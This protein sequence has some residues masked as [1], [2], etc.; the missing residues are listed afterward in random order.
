[1]IQSIW[2]RPQCRSQLFFALD[3]CPVCPG[4]LFGA[5]VAELIIVGTLER[6]GQILLLHP[7]VGVIVG[8]FVILPLYQRILAVAVLVLQLTRDGAGPACLHIRD[9]RIDGVMST[10]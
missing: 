4:C 3:L 10:V 6:V 1:M 8:I 2:I 9:G 7:V 5:V